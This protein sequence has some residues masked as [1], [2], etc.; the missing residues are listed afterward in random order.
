MESG[1]PG[2]LNFIYIARSL[3]GLLLRSSSGLMIRVIF[4]AS[5]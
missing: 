4:T 2:I 1:G 3:K 5:P